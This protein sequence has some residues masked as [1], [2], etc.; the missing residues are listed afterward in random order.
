MTEA[1][2]VLL[3]ED[4]APIALL[5]REALERSGFRVKTVA[6]GQRALEC[7][8]LDDEPTLLILDY[9]LPDMTGADVIEALGERIERLPVVV[10]T[11]YPD[12]EVERSMRAAGID[13][14]LIKDLGFRF[15]DILPDI[16]RAVVDSHAG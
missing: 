12:P 6:L 7:L 16:A 14:Y 13:D 1:P 10:I 3:V 5:E 15:L 2:T 9:R 8:S 4:E 11:G